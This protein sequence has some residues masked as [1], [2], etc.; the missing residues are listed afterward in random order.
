[1]AAIMLPQILPIPTFGKDGRIT[2]STL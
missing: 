1:M 2:D